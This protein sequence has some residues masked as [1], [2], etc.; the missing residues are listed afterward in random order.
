M[1]SRGIDLRGTPV[2]KLCIKPLPVL[3]LKNPEELVLILSLFISQPQGDVS[4]MCIK[5]CQFSLR[6]RRGHSQ[7]TLNIYVFSDISQW[8]SQ[9][10]MSQGMLVIYALNHT[11]S[12]LQETKRACLQAAFVQ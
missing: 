5:P 6:R 1:V 12:P 3:L 10:L 8:S 2:I 7:A 4:D 9:G 11:C